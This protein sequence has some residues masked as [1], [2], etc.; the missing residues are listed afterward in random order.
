MR[1]GT[2]GPR[3]LKVNMATNKVMGGGGGEG[4]VGFFSL[5][6]SPCVPGG[7]VRGPASPK[8]S[9]FFSTEYT[10]FVPSRARTWGLHGNG[11]KCSSTPNH[12]FHVQTSGLFERL[13]T[14]HFLRSSRSKAGRHQSRVLMGFR[15]WHLRC[16]RTQRP[17]GKSV[18]TV[19]Q[20]RTEGAAANGTFS[21]L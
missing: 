5:G 17:R 16:P 18:V 1:R 15:P 6:F 12:L 11:G 9:W 20:R 19:T 3:R 4:E 21:W 7:E 10:F 14:P 13:V 8:D 2:S